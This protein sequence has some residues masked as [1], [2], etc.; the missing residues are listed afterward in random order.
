[1]LLITQDEDCKASPG[2]QTKVADGPERSNFSAAVEMTQL[3]AKQK[4][5]NEDGKYGQPF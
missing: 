3:A 2:S 5:K 1:M 4:K